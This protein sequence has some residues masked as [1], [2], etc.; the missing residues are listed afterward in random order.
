VL[1][2]DHFYATA[3]FVAFGST[4]A[5][6]LV[7]TGLA[8]RLACSVFGL[9]V[10]PEL[11]VLDPLPSPANASNGNPKTIANAIVANRM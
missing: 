5:A 6:R 1:S 9:Y 4:A 2:I 11:L 8:R 7:V 10:A 3:I